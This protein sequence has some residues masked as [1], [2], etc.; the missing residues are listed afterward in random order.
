MS[1]SRNVT[2]LSQSRAWFSDPAALP[3]RMAIGGSSAAASIRG[4]RR[5]TV[6]W[7]LADDVLLIEPAASPV[8]LSTAVMYWTGPAF[9]FA[10]YAALVAPN[11]P[12]H[13][14]PPQLPPPLSV[15]H[16]IVVS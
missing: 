14:W 13:F 3:K 5:P 4:G 8:R 15:S 6:T 10:A 1:S 12:L 7:M 11:D 16:V 9:V 2:F